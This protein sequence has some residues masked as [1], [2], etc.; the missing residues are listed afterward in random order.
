MPAGKHVGLTLKD[1]SVNEAIRNL[2]EYHI[3]AV[4]RTRAGSITRVKHIKWGWIPVTQYYDLQKIHEAVPFIVEFIKGGYMLKAAL[5]TVAVPVDIVA[6]GTSIPLGLMIVEAAVVLWAIDT[7]LG[8]TLYA[9]LDLL[10]LILPFGELWLLY[11]GGGYFIQAFTATQPGL[12][13]PGGASLPDW[14][15][16]SGAGIAITEGTGIYDALKSLVGNLSVLFP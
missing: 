5:Y 11:H 9:W 8:N 12:T 1:T 13:L 15:L 6:T 2:A 10:A 7:A 4:R 14:I 16:F 3:V